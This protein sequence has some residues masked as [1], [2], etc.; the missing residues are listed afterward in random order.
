MKYGP[1]SAGGSTGT[2]T[3]WTPMRQVGAAARQ[4]LIA[5]AAESWSVPAAECTTASGQVK[6]AASNRSVGYGAIAT[7]AA[8]MTPP[9]LASVKLKE[10]K[11]YRI[12]GTKVHGVDNVKIVSGQPLFAI[13]FTLPGMLSAVYEKCPVFGG[14]VVSANLDEIKALPGVRHAF[15]VEGV[16]D[17]NTLVGGVAIVADTW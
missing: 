17:P 7:K 16:G 2:P 11:D 15:V 3:N 14:K 12:I 6:H 5:A 9:E 10:K 13:D 8:A 4:M 1:Q